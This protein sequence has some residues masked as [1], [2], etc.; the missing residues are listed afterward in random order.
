MKAVIVRV[1]RRATTVREYDAIIVVLGDL[2]LACDLVSDRQIKLA[3]KIADDHE[4]AFVFDDANAE[5]VRTVLGMP[6]LDAAG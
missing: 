5:R 1:A 2:H 3:K 4:A 6:C